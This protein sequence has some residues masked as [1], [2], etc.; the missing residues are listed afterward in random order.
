LK[1]LITGGCGF[2]GANLIKRLISEGRHTIRIIDNLSVG[3][4]EN[5]ASAGRF[6]EKTSPHIDQTNDHEDSP[7]V[8]LIVGDILDDQLAVEAARNM[9]VIVHL[10]ANTGVRSS[11]RDPH[12]DCMI[13]V[14][15]ALNYLEAARRNKVKRFVFASSSAVIGNCNP[16]VHEELPPHPISAYGASKLAGEGYCSAYFSAFGVE[17][18]ALRFGNV[19]GP[20]SNHKGSVVAKFIRQATRGETLEIYGDGKQTRDFVF[21]GDLIRAIYLS[22]I[23]DDIGGEIFQIATNCET[24]VDKLMETLLPLLSKAGI[25][26]VQTHHSAP[27]PEEIRRIFSDTSKA[28]RILG[29]QPQVSLTEGLQYT[30]NSFMQS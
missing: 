18:V 12:S 14:V 17:T 4:R 22:M 30:V 2:I 11:T 24:S 3:T 29:W 19:F 9:D 7:H 23:T 27:R 10:A 25:E 26:K 6:I 13:N 15:G 8:E 28:K 20:G 1:I 21:V 16:P 5:L